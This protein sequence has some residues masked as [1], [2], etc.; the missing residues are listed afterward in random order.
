MWPPWSSSVFSF[1][2]NMAFPTC[3]TV[4]WNLQVKESFPLQQESKTT[5]LLRSW[6]R[7]QN[8]TKWVGRCDLE[9]VLHPQCC[10]F[11]SGKKIGHC[12]PS[13]ASGPPSFNPRDL[14][15]LTECPPHKDIPTTS[16]FQGELNVGDFLTMLSSHRWWAVQM[17]DLNPRL[18]ASEARGPSTVLT[19]TF[20]VWV[21]VVLEALLHSVPPT[22][23]A[24]YGSK[25][26]S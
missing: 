25:R 26:Q 8:R 7:N 3:P 20:W 18:S 14:F 19:S 2:M 23:L 6:I 10:C 15:Y 1:S 22:E 12:L 24:T 11:Y 16:I 21:P 4:S 5:W 9:F 17:L 13:Q